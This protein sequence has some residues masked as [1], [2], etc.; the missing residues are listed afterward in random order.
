[1]HRRRCAVLLSILIL[2]SAFSGGCTSPLASDSPKTVLEGYIQAYNQ[3][4]V[5][6]IYQMLLVFDTPDMHPRYS[7]KDDIAT[8]IQESRYDQGLKIVGYDITREY[9]VENYAVMT[10]VITWEDPVGTLTEETYDMGFLYLNGRWRMVNLILPNE[11][12]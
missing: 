4:D 12:Y 9:E 7:N 10:V 3:G 5:D 1:M 2:A 11:G 8:R 6:S